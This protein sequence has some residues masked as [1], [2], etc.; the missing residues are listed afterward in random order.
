MPDRT[1]PGGS[2]LISGSLASVPDEALMAQLRRHDEAA[3]RALYQRYGG[4]VYSIASRTLPESQD[5]EEVTQDVFLRLWKHA[6]AWDP[7]RGTLAAWLAATARHAAIDQYRRKQR[8][9][10]APGPLS[11]DEHTALWETLVTA[12]GD[13]SDRQQRVAAM[14]QRLEAPQREAIVLAYFYGMA[15]S[16]IAEHLHRPLGTVKSHIRQG[17]ERLRQIWLAQEGTG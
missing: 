15:Q 8:R 16:E 4:L 13:D 1:R 17:M 11:M 7:A 9:E 6:A 10:P 3:L 2:D 5:A 12:S 14:L